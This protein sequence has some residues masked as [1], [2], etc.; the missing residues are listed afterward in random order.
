M[1][2]E[3]FRA[4]VWLRWRLSRNQFVR[5]GQINAILAI[6]VLVL[7]VSSAVG[8]A[9]GGVVLG[10]FLGAKAPAPV[11][12]LVW[13][14]VMF[15]FLLFW[16]IG[17]LTEIQRS[18]SVDLSKLLH[19]PLTLQ[20][21]F[22]FNYAASHFTPS[23][24]M[25]LPAMIG[26]CVGQAASGGPA[27]VLVL[28]VLLAFL[29]LVTSWTYWLRGWLAALMV[30]KRRRRAIVVWLTIGFVLVFQL[31]NLFFNSSW[32]KAKT[33]NKPRQSQGAPSQSRST[34]G[35]FALPEIVEQAHLI[36]PPGWV[37]YSAMSLKDGNAWPAL[38]ATV[39]SGLLGAFG[40]MRAYRMTL[41]FYQGA[42]SGEAAK[43]A[44]VAVTSTAPAGPRKPLLV[45][46]VIPGLPEDVTALALATFRSLMRAPELKM[47]LIMPVVVCVLIGG[48][49]MTKLKKVP[50]ESLVGFAVTG[51]VAFAAFSLAPTM[52]NMFG[53]DRNGF[54][55]LVLLPTRRDRVLFAKNLAFLPL[56]AAVALALLAL[57]GFLLRPAASVW[58]TALVQLP[59][60][61]LLFSLM[62]NLAAILM[63]YRMAPGTLQA[64]KPKPIVFVGVFATMLATPIIL[65]P[66]AIP[67]GLQFLFMRMEWLSWLPV[68]VIAAVLI[69]AA[70]AALYR[71]LLPL[72]GRLLQRREQV[73]L[74]EVTEEVE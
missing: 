29:F 19:L 11:L 48:M 67:P 61:F 22:V 60:A 4:I 68:N 73:I 41:R 13:D 38:A 35:G 7:L 47:A 15:V 20:Q 25:L 9:V 16:I 21:V 54:R 70:V 50:A 36:V 49:H 44:P 8:L 69:L 74:R 56:I 23:L 18:E 43:S 65:A 58:L 59:T 28:P 57:I 27:L 37:G 39:A 64:K 53:L 52:A 62:C 51:M 40:L 34:R 33:R 10:V 32:F 1:N 3:Q 2:W 46:R 66:I 63:P 72:E 31:P 24:G 45:E 42:Q 55:A 71:I 12:M 30:N 5:G 26:L 14:G 17:L 6:V